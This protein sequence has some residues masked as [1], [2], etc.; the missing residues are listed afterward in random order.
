[1]TKS[2]PRYGQAASRV[3]TGPAGAVTTGLGTGR[4]AVRCTVGCVVPAADP[5]CTTSGPAQPATAN[6][7]TR[8]G[9]FTPR[10]LA[11][12]SPPQHVGRWQ[13]D[14][15]P[16]AGCEK[17][18]RTGDQRRSAEIEGEFPGRAEIDDIADH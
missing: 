12:C 2:V 1:M 10:R 15:A 3:T 5:V 17:S 7:R 9:S 6:S 11:L 8:A 13:Y 16:V 14:A 4:L 18:R